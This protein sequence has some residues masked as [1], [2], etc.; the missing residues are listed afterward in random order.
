MAR[1]QWLA[2]SFVR[3]TFAFVAGIV[4]AYEQKQFYAWAFPLTIALLVSYFL[5]W[6]FI[7]KHRRYTFQSLL[8]LIGLAAVLAF[9]FSLS[10]H[11]QELYRPAHLSHFGDS[12]LFYEATLISPLQE[13]NKSWKAELRLHQ[14]Y[15]AA[16]GWQVLQGKILA[17]IQKDAPALDGLHTGTRLLIKGRPQAVE[18]P[19]NPREFDFQSYLS[20]QNIYHQH[21]LSEG[22]FVIIAEGAPS[23][24]L[25]FLGRVHAIRRWAY[26]ALARAVGSPQEA[27]L[28][29]ALVL[30]V[31]ESLD[32]EIKEAYTKAGATHVLAVSGLHVGIIYGI[33]LLLLR[34]WQQS[35]AG[36]LRFCVVVLAAL[37]SYAFLTG[38]S[39]SVMRAVTMFSI[40]TLAKTSH[41]NTNI[42]NTLAFSAFVLL[43]YD[44][45]MIFQVGF[46]LSY[47]AVLGIV[48][49]QPRIYALWET[50]YRFLDYLWQ[51][52]AVSIAAQVATFPITLYYFHQYPVYGLLSNL[53]V[54]P[55]AFV[56]LYG[57]I[58]SILLSFVPALAAVVGFVLRYLVW[59]VNQYIF[60]IEQ[61]QG[62]VVQGIEFSAW[63]L[64]LSYASIV[65]FILLI[66]Q[67][68]WSY[69]LGL[70]TLV[71]VLSGHRLAVQHRQ[72]QQNRVDFYAIRGHSVASF[73][74]GRLLHWQADSSFLA[75]SKLRSFH[76]QNHLDWLGIRQESRGSVPAQYQGDCFTLIVW[77]GQSFLFVEAPCSKDRLS[78]LLE[79]VRPA[80]LILQKESI[81]SLEGINALADVHVIIDTSYRAALAQ[82]LRQQAQSQGLRC[83]VL[84]KEGALSV[85]FP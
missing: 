48:Y 62:A 77:Q 16:K 82:K 51:I 14:G 33:F 52:T 50:K 19:K 5:L 39:P 66:E 54:I 23:W 31:K 9:G 78:A 6:R 63:A 69:F 32:P 10:Q 8:G 64:W 83:H 41:R 38:L 68:K 28:L 7:P 11:K 76:L 17:Y 55:A 36:R 3:I 53:L 27:S 22:S 80:Y 45:A 1:P 24:S 26:E 73:V 12:L 85:Y 4:L 79:Q 65:F 67:R 47:M 37:W 84:A 46:Q 74:Q 81:R 13:K 20:K 25:R 61:L 72:L 2:Y 57:G 35:R 43:C 18:S 58:L 70:C 59:F 15:G 44:P 21:Y 42:Y 40:F 75:D 30:G 34:S 29:Q 60:I 71:F 49:L 56:M